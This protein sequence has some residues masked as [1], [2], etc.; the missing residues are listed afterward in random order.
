MYSME[1]IGRM[2][3]HYRIKG[4]NVELVTRTLHNIVC[5]NVLVNVSN[6][7]AN[8]VLIMMIVRRQYFLL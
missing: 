2:K 5:V 7:D 4:F 3:R 1:K 6:E 8:I